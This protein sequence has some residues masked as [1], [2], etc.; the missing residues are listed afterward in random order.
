MDTL[1]SCQSGSHRASFCPLR[2]PTCPPA[3][4]SSPGQKNKQN[5]EM[6]FPGLHLGP[7][8]SSPQANQQMT[9]DTEERGNWGLLVQKKKGENLGFSCGIFILQN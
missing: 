9:E 2:V 5:G 8:A 6:F 3:R 1:T 7:R 4:L